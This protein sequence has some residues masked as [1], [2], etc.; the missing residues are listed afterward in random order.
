VKVR[1][2][3]QSSIFLLVAL[4]RNVGEQVQR[5]ADGEH[6]EHLDGDAERILEEKSTAAEG[7]V[8]NDRA[9]FST[10]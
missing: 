2:P 5:P 9:A 1:N 3:S 4:P 10:V 6:C 8:E 7:N